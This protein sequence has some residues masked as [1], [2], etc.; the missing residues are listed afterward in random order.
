MEFLVELGKAKALDLTFKKSLGAVAYHAAC[1][2]RAQKMGYPG[3]RVL[4]K[5][6]DT[7]VRVVEECT[8]VDGTWGMKAEHYATGRRYAQKVVRATA[9][10]EPA[11]V[12]SDCTLAGLRLAHEG[13]V[14]VVH[15][16]EALAE[17]YGLLEPPGVRGIVPSPGDRS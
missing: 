16:V 5:I 9:D 12:V 10:V 8:A 6:P 11:L 7:D 2:L 15:P 3:Q 13:G 4:S 14:R 17:A 1:H